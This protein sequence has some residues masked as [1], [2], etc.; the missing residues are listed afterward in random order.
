MEDMYCKL[1]KK[2]CIECVPITAKTHSCR[3]KRI[4]PYRQFLMC[5]HLRTEYKGIVCEVE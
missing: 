1:L 3:D 5:K 4:V 2:R